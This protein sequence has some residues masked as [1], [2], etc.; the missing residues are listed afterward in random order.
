MSNSTIILII[1]AAIVLSSAITSFITSRKM[2][3]KV[4]YMLDA[5]EDKELNF[6]FDEKRLFGRRFNRT[7]NRLRNIFDKERHEIIEQEKYFGLMLDHVRTGVVV[8]E[9]D[10]RVN[11]CNKTALSLLGIATFGHIRQLRP[12]SESLYNAFLTVTDSEEERASY[13]NESGK[14]TIALTASAATIGK[15]AVRVVAFNDISSEIAENEQ[16]SWSRL[17]RVLTHEIMNTVTPIASLSETL[18][19]FENVDEEVRNGLDTISQSSRGLIKF[20]DSYRNLTRVAP[21]VKKAFYFRELAERVISLTKEQALVSGAE[22]I[23]IEKSDDILLYADEGQITQ[24]LINLVKNAI[25]AE[26][27]HIE[28]TAEINLSE[29]VIINVINNGSPISKESQEEIFVPFYTTKQEGTG[30]GLSLSRQIMR[31]HNGTL[32]LTKSDA[33]ETVFTLTFR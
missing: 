5:L 12:V 10:G 16:Q 23:Y 14:M 32:S 13:Y 19:N 3:G 22:C 1:L 20:V 6:R 30:I 4:S 21:P 28:I 2:R 8:I 24:I 29:H 26:A 25:Q 9:Q 27:R 31:L 18:L 17:I 11:Y 7:L 15:S 33:R